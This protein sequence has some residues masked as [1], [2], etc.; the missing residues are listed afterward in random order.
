MSMRIRK[1]YLFL[2]GGVLLLGALGWRQL[3]GPLLPAYELSLRPLQQVVVATGRV[4]SLSRTQIGTE[5][6]G[7]VLERR[8]QEGD[9]VKAGDVLVVLRSDDLDARVREAQAALQTLLQSTRPQAA[10]ALRQAEAQLVQAV[11]EHQRR[12]ELFARQL[13]SRETLEQAE[14]AETVART[15]AERARLALDALAAGRSEQAQLRERLK[16]ALAAQA[17]S[18]LRSPASGVVLTRNVEPG[19]LVQPGRVLLEIALQGDTEIVVP[20]DEKNLAALALGQSAQCVADAW[21]LRPFAAQLTFIAPAVD[22]QRGVVELRL[23][24]N[25]V[26]DYLRQDMTVS[27][28]IQTAQRAQALAVPNDALVAV[29]GN[30]ATVLRV[31]AGRLSHV[32]VQLGLRGLALSEVIAGLAPGD[33]VLAG[34]DAQQQQADGKRVRL[35]LQLLPD[36]ADSSAGQRSEL[37]VHFD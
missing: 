12:R 31:R 10:A 26:P 23:K 13:V 3:Q 34:A 11:R 33:R 17:R 15:T 35:T 29:Q 32:P 28:N 8:V 19:D 2:G 37:P 22:A 6:T 1:L 30:S 18:V 24:V 7:V 36:P 25:P 16:A 4:S 5:I 20:V 21:P 14:Q 9:R 27:V